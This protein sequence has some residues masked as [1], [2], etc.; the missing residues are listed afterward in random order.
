[1]IP[2]QMTD[3]ILAT[4]MTDE[5]VDAVDVTMTIMVAVGL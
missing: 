4:T 2:G 1:M 3:V 5:V